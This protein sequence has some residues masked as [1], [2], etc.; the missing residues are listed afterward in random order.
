MRYV[1]S[2][3]ARLALLAC[4]TACTTAGRI[5]PAPTAANP[6][7]PWVEFPAD[8]HSNQEAAY[9]GCSNDVNLRASV[10]DPRDLEGG[11]ALGPGNGLRESLAVG[12]YESGQTKPLQSNGP[13]TPTIV[14]SGSQGG[15]Q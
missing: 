8:R 13:P 1:V 4:A 2:F 5:L 10:E 6:C 12:Q 11:R 15:A 7:P 3:A 14:F 9:L